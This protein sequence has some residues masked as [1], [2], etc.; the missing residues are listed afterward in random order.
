MGKQKDGLFFNSQCYFG[1]F[2]KK[3]LNKRHPQRHTY[4]QH[5]VALNRKQV[6]ISSGA[7]I[8]KAY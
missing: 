3:T 2:Q 4:L 1:N 8:K 5:M 6:E 7:T